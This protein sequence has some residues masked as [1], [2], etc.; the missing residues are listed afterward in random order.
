MTIWILAI[1]TLALAAL[2]GWRQGAI[3]AAITFFGIPIATLLAAPIGKIL[4]PLVKFLGVSNPILLW[5]LS[6]L[7]GFALI[8]IIFAVVAFNVHRKVDLFYKYSAGDL[9]LAL[10]ERLNSRVGI[11]LGLLNGAVYF[12]LISFVF[13]NLSY[14]T[15][16]AGIPEKQ[17]GLIR[18]VNMLGSDLQD[19]GLARTASAVGTLPPMYYQLADLSGYLMQNPQLAP[20]LAEYPALTSLWERDDMQALLQDSA[21]TNALA[22]GAT[23]NEVLQAPSVQEFL[24]N[25]ESSQRVWGIFQTNL[26][27]IMA[28]LETGKSAK[29]DDIKVLGTWELNVNVTVAWLRQERPR[30]TASEMR[31]TRAMMNHAYAQTRLLLT[32]DNQV[33][34][35]NLPLI[36]AQ[37]G[38]P[39]TAELQNWKGDWNP[40]GTGYTLHITF[41]DQ[42]KFMTADADGIR[43]TLKD[44]NNR[45]IFDRID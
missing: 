5:A 2:A 27:D 43:M 22:S 10:W 14:F 44:G 7:C 31:A 28:Y 12:I 42:E 11:C 32:G 37:P 4:L 19:T 35:K 20:R 15:A 21:L 18:L 34:V 41:N 9:R 26:T 45:L 36:K 3:R 25:K 24:K 8:S 13:F 23:L 33:F 39:T 29:Y 1:L 16:Q 30:M 6:P 38:Q 40:D 17:S